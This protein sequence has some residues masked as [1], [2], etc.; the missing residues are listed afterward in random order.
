VDLGEQLAPHRIVEISLDPS[1][2]A[3]GYT[4]AIDSE[5]AS[6][7]GADD[8]GIFYAHATLGQLAKAHGGRLPV[9]TIRDHP[10]LA[11]RGVMLDASR[12]KVPTLETLFEVVERLASWKINHFQLYIEHTFAHRNH[13]EVS[14]GASPYSAADIKALDN[15]CAAHHV[16]LVANR[17]CLG[18]M[19]RWLSHDRYQH[20]RL[21]AQTPASDE[22][23]L[24]QPAQDMGVVGPPMTLD[25]NQAESVELIEELLNELLPLLR[26]RK[27]HV[28]LD[29]A[30][31]LADRIDD[32]F[33]W[34]KTIQEFDVI[35][36]D[37]YEVLI[38][39][40]MV[41]D[42][43]DRLGELGPGVTVCDWGYD[44][45]HPFDARAEALHS[46]GITFMTAAGTSSWLS[47]GG[48]V[49]N[50]IGNCRSAISAA[51]E[52]DGRGFLVADWGDKGHLQQLPISDPGLAYAAA[53][54]WCLATSTDVELGPALSLHAYDDPSCG[55]ANAVLSLGEVYRAVDVAVPNTSAVVRH[56]YFPDEPVGSSPTEGLTVTGLNKARV[57]VDQARVALGTVRPGTNNHRR[58]LD[59]LRWTADLIELMIDDATARITAT[60]GE[61]QPKGSLEA[62]DATTRSHL[63][64]RMEALIE[65]HEHLW[66]DRNRPGGLNESRSYLK[67]VLNS[68]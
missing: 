54:S 40:D 28:G 47:I 43:P 11:V 5:G 10:D 59:E 4:I 25:I 36:S 17:G 63:A 57:L 66:L 53:A 60:P 23:P 62:V 30:P 1:L 21:Q 24:E 14:A 58:T 3:Q 37:G 20:L 33:E 52:H 45:D 61:D 44:L 2:P 64:Q 6:I 56:L 55:L 16:E 7:T 41:A 8:D 65:S 9:G 67:A 49:A 50:A 46:A 68:Y 26:S 34:L 31:E 13:Q 22:Q 35:R 38:W 18:H 32:Y 48:R 51:I 27:V 12:G 15:H 29:E 42:H 19:E 39:G